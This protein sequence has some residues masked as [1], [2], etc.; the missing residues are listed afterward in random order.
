[1]LSGRPVVTRSVLYQ[2]ECRCEFNFSN[3]PFDETD[4]VVKF[5]SNKWNSEQVQFMW[6]H[7]LGARENRR[8]SNFSNGGGSRKNRRESSFL[9]RSVDEAAVGGGGAEQV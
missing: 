5:S 4:M 7:R 8:V 2:P 1:M 9:K 3:Y 6:T